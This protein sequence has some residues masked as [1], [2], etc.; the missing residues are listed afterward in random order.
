MRFLPLSLRFSALL[1]ATAIV[2]V[3]SAA[4]HAQP[5]R[6]TISV[7]IVA[8]NLGGTVIK[9]PGPDGY[10][11]VTSQWEAM[12]TRFTAAVPP[13]GDL[14]GAYLSAS[15][16]E[17]LRAGQPPLY[18]YWTMVTVFREARTHVSSPAE[19]GRITG[20][21]RETAQAST[22][23]NSQVKAVTAQIEEALSKEYSKDVKLD[24]SKPKF[25]QEFGSR[26]N[27][28]SRLMLMKYAIQADAQEVGQPMVL[29]TMSLVLIKQR[30]VTVLTYKRLES[31]ED[32]DA[33]TQLTTKW[34][35]KI[36]AA[37]K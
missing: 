2:L 28:Y 15:D 13:Q 4:V 23:E 1:I 7:D 20:Y 34:I 18:N 16:C 25:L 32:A 33:L 12:R 5:T 36:L 22:L 31:K 24:L 3:V 21:A 11:E 17:L 30:I 10:E 29:A 37:N 9:L 19:F 8:P 26:P 27:V 14:L 6:T 35:N